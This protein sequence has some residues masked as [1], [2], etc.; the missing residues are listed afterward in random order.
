MSRS[1]NRSLGR[2]VNWGER[3][4]P[5]IAKPRLLLSQN[6]AKSRERTLKT[7]REI[8]DRRR[9]QP[10]NHEDRPA[11]TFRAAHHRLSLPS[12]RRTPP[13]STPSSYFHPSNWP[14][15]TVSFR[16][17][18]KVPICVRRRVRRE[19]VFATTGGGGGMPPRRFNEFSKIS[20]RR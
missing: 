9:Y 3:D 2:S 6:Y 7:L 20:C 16:S 18:T 10:T 19:V 5:H 8:E 1:R 11:R 12:V 15:A 17:P 4:R 13:P 14:T